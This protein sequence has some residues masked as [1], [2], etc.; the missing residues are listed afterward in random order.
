[1]KQLIIGFNLLFFLF[2]SS[3]GKAKKTQG[4]LNDKI[5][6]K[7]N[8]VLVITDDQGYGDVGFHGNSIIKTP[9]LDTL[10][11]QSTELT[12][13]HVGTTC[14][15]SRAG[16]LTGR[17]SNRNNA[18]HTIA[19]CSILNSE[20]ETLAD[21]LEK[22]GYSTSMFGK[23]HLGD[24]YPFRP[25]D[26]GFKEALY[27]GGGGVGQT[28]DYWNNNYINDTYFRNGKPEKFEGYCTDVWFSEA[29]SHIQAQKE[30]PFFTYLALNAPHGPFNVPQEYFDIYAD[31]DLT[32]RQ[33]RF[34]GMITNLDENL[35]KLIK[36]LKASG[37]WDNTI[38]I[39]TT[40]NGTAAGISNEKGKQR[41]YNAGLRGTK[42]SQYDGGHRVPFLISWPAKGITSKNIK[43]NNELVAHVDLLP[44][45]AKLCGLD[46]SPKKHLDG[47]D[48]SS[49]LLGETQQEKR[50][51]VVDTQRNQW[52]E[53]NRNS[54][55]MQGEWR[56]V[57]GDELYNLAEDFGQESNVAADYPDKVKAMQDFYN[58]W[59][60]STEADMHYAKIPLT[61]PNETSVLL[62]IHDLHS[63]QPIPW[64]QNLIRKGEQS[65]EGYYL[66][67][68]TEPGDYQ[69]DLYRYPPESD[70]AMNA[71]VEE[72]ESKPNW[73]G[74][75]EGVGF[76]VI[77]GQVQ[78]N[79]IVFHEKG[80]ASDTHIS[81]SGQLEKGT[82]KLSAYYQV[83]DKNSIPTNYINVIK[84]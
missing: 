3:C 42:G 39:F 49:V 26:R 51:L 50:M 83:E 23:W 8:I 44:T 78:L 2:L 40:D 75:S 21:V 47:K 16:L 19:G 63:E 22:N 82:Y 69:F 15:P 5:E 59:W 10:A 12:N 52:P 60:V 9:N 34:Y 11:A 80:I 7:P 72:I 84:K 28:P 61:A 24:N 29:I 6:T 46:Y 64:N 20:E 65:P 25:Q 55:V 4:N 30:T 41:G 13:F 76:D 27:H 77:G 32:D 35:G 48:M 33:K 36:Q 73:D 67:E 81:V 68:V 38:F 56:L 74:L 1:M 31:S 71:T 58:E 62:T 70:L 66:V 45:L 18:W 37:Q 79:D 14:A 57:N 54:C 17:N 43:S 53:K